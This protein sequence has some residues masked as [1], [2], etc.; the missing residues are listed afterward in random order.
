MCERV[1]LLAALV[2]CKSLQHHLIWLGNGALMSLGGNREREHKT[3][4]RKTYYC[5][6]VGKVASGLSVA[7]DKRGKKIGRGK[8]G[9]LWR[10]SCHLLMPTAA[11][12]SYKG[13]KKQRWRWASAP[14]LQLDLYFYSTVLKKLLL[15]PGQQIIYIFSRA[16]CSRNIEFSVEDIKGSQARSSGG[17]KSRSLKHSVLFE[18]HFYCCWWSH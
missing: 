1:C 13:R 12:Y 18:A 17:D 14:R 5:E 6:A 2:L 9:G 10:Y 15:S 8:N 7:T 3:V 4:Q 16:H 11:C